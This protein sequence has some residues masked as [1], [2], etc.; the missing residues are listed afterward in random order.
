LREDWVKANT[1]V[2]DEEKLPGDEDVTD[3]NAESLKG[4]AV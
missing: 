2:T 3:F 1:I 4:E